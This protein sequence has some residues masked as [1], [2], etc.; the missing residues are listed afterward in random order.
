MKDN[1]AQQH[2]PSQFI[3]EEIYKRN[4]ELIEERRRIEQLLLNITDAVF[5]VN[6][7]FKITLANIVA[8]NIFPA[9]TIDQEDKTDI[10][11]VLKLSNEKTNELIDIKK[12]CF[13]SNDKEI[14]YD[15][16]YTNEKG[17]KKYFIL[18]TATIKYDDTNS[19]CLITLSDITKQKLSERAKDD[20]LSVAAHELRTP[21]TII[22]SYLWR[23]ASKG[24]AT[25]DV[26]QKANINRIQS[27]TERLINLVNDILN[28]SR[29]EQGRL[30]FEISKYDAED[31]LKQAIA[32]LE[33]KAQDNNIYL[34][35]DTN[36][37]KGINVY[38]DKDKLIEIM[39]NLVG[40]A[41]K[42]TKKGGIIVQ[43]E[44]TEDDF[45]KVSI[46]DTGV[47]IDKKD[48][49]S[50]FRKFGRLDNSY[51]TVAESGGTGLGLFIVK[52][53]V[54]H[55]GG[56]IGVFSEGIG[57]GSTFWFTLPTKPVK[58]IASNSL[59]NTIAPTGSTLNTFKTTGIISKKEY[60]KSKVNT[61]V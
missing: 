44:K 10:H 25:L 37:V 51:T 52:M 47:G 54:E 22:K 38:V 57:K 7:D 27:A 46:I 1:T 23:L 21:L 42:F 32:G 5:V 55:L 4:K 40:N 30:V 16:S 28:I 18:K 3:T 20:F 9:F 2:I 41:I 61:I 19:E 17:E 34:K 35:L 8:K 33:L 13:T 39:F 59:T 12:Q 50:L 58:G 56:K 31:I 49:S 24:G 48:M 60:E 26:D 11:N 29:F 43:A 53:Y 6:K 14:I 36:A 15:T 45:I